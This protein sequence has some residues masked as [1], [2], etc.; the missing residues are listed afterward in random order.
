ME[1]LLWQ[2]WSR[3]EKYLAKQF[4]V[5]VSTH[6]AG[7]PLQWK[8]E[9]APGAVPCLQLLQY[10]PFDRALAGANFGAV[11]NKSYIYA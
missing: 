9:G 10:E 6:G 1:R 4:L 11:P 3:F 5:L 7:W 8:A 2:S